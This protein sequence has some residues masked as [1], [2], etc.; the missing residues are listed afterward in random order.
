MSENTELVDAVI[1][2]AKEREGRRELTCAEAFGIAEQF[3]VE[4]GE[5]GRICNAY[6]IKI[7]ECQLGCFR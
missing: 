6:K 4:K 5:V 2:A 1:A 3:G 7:R